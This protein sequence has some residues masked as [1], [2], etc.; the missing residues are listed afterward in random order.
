[1]PNANEQVAGCRNIN[2]NC[3]SQLNF[4]SLALFLQ[5]RNPAV[6]KPHQR[7]PTHGRPA[8]DDTGI[9][10]PNSPI[11]F[12]MPKEPPYGLFCQWE[13]T[14]FTVPRETLL[15]LRTAHPGHVKSP[16]AQRPSSSSE[17]VPT[18]MD[19]NCV[20]QF[21]MFCKALYFN[22]KISANL[23]MATKDPSLQ[24]KYGRAVKDF[25]DYLWR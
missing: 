7:K 20:G 10:D 16:P 5:Q 14:R 22:D 17:S 24:K 2:I 18:E 9:E 6:M 23:I 21:M 12:Y 19:F 1:M 11:F 13:L 15:W 25:S 3:F 4:Q 8:K